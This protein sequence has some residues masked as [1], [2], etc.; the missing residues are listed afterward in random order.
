MFLMQRCSML[1]HHRLA[2]VD[3]DMWHFW[4]NT[5]ET[6]MVDG[7]AQPG[8]ILFV[9]SFYGSGYWADG[10]QVGDL[11]VYIEDVRQGGLERYGKWDFS[12]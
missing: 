10:G 4:A 9:D 12:L 8:R 1:R 7:E 6:L 11:P 2:S 5:E 3:N